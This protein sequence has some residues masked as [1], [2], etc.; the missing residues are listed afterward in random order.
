MGP[1]LVFGF[2]TA[3]DGEKDPRCLILTFALF[4]VTRAAQANTSAL[5][6]SRCYLF[7]VPP[8]L[9][10][11]SWFRLRNIFIHGSAS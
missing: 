10:F 1:D 7:I 3:A 11:Y 2:I 9:H 6:M 4:Q 8:P 5:L